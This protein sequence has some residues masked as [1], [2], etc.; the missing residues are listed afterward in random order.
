MAGRILPV[1]LAVILVVTMV[2]ASVFAEQ[3]AGAGT[4]QT[5]R[6]QIAG[7]AQSLEGAAAHSLDLQKALQNAA[8]RM[9]FEAQKPLGRTLR[10]TT[11]GGRLESRGTKTML[12]VGVIAGAAIAM[13]AIEKA[14]PTATPATA[15]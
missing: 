3:A 14:G 13:Y 8:Q 11:S 5:E 6:A 15:R 2:P 12:Y 1:A 9:V 4:E 10:Q 7:T